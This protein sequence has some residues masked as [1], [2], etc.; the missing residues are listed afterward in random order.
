MT[1]VFIG[2]FN[3]DEFL[4]HSNLQEQVSLESYCKTTKGMAV[5]VELP[6]QVALELKNTPSLFSLDR[7]NINR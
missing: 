7:K 3:I 6:T 5:E 1:S 4:L 2:G